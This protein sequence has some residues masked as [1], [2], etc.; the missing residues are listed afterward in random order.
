[1][2]EP[3]NFGLKENPFSNRPVADVEHWAGMPE[4]KR[5]LRDVVSSVRPDDIGSSEC[6]LLHG[7]YGAGKSHALR[8]FAREI[9]N[10]GDGCAIYISEIMVGAGL[11]FADL[12]PRILDQLQGQILERTARV[13]NASVQQCV[14]GPG[15]TA[16]MSVNPEMAIENKV[17]H[18][19]R[20]LVKS[21]CNTGKIPDAGNEVYMVVK[22]LAS[23]FR[24][25]TLPIGGNEPPYKAAYLFLDEV[26][27][28]CEARATQQM[29]FFGALRMLINQV[30]ERFGLVLSFTF[31]TATLEAVVP[32]FLKER[33]TRGYIECDKLTTDGAKRFVK[34]FLGFRR[35]DGFSPPQPFYPFSESA[36]DGIFENESVMVPRRILSRMG[37]VWERAFR[38]ENLAPGQEISREMAEK[39]LE[40]I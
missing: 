1:M 24:V 17:P 10:R 38:Q 8:Y 20:S 14:E 23:L 16:G 27:T 39:I 15:G 19:D 21:L 9:N 4:M 2:L 37:R 25:M 33:V 40:G 26:E 22:T 29:S 12:Y 7:S 13:V 11:N 28:A 30:T 34:D 31:E 3:A 6:V 32:E 36:I 18:Q 35:P 5:S